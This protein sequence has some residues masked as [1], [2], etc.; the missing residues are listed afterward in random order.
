[1]WFTDTSK[2]IDWIEITPYNKGNLWKIRC[3]FNKTFHVYYGT[4]RTV[5]CTTLQDALSFIPAPTNN[6]KLKP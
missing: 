1:M 5:Y 4:V 3:L 6:Y 2:A